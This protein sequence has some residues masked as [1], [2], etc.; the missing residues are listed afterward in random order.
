MIRYLRTLYLGWLIGLLMAGALL[1]VSG[2][3]SAPP[4][5]EGPA[6]D[7]TLE[8]FN[9]AA[10]LAFDKGRLQ[11]AASFYRK[12]LDRA[13]VRDDTA[14]ILD[15]QYNLALCLMHL[16]SYEEALGV[17]RNANTEMALAG[18]GHSVD[19]L[20][21]EAT[22][23][24]HNGNSAEA[25]KITDQILSIPTQDASVITSKTHFLRGLI[26]SKQGDID[27][28]REAIA[29]LGQPEHPRLRADRQELV[30]HLDMAEQK[31]GAAV[32]AFD[33]AAKLRREALDYRTMVK[34]LALAG[35]ASEKAGR[36]KEASIRYLRAGRSAVLQGLFDDALK[37]L[38]RA[39]QIANTAGQAQIVRET[40]IYLRQIEELTATSPESAGKN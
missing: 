25:W 28:L 34:V 38:N 15:A 32:E 4:K 5:Q 6:I 13:Y 12:A 40:H 11:Q 16:Q 7:E 14:A 39:E 20:L 3:G 2:C 37:W 23:L 31:W 22:I 35:K 30:G 36:A 10:L 27:Q 9:R 21:L 19:F 29:A 1:A 33:G 18:R 8:R 17:V 26:A 24:H